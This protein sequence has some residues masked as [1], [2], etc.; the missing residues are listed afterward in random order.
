VVRDQRGHGT[1]LIALQSTL[2]FR[3]HDHQKLACSPDQFRGPGLPA[4]ILHTIVT[5]SRKPPC[6]EA[7]GWSKS[8]A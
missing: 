3:G 8:A 1:G 5:V 2:P 4:K 6:A 7:V